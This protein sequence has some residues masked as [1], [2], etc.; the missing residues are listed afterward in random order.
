MK[1]SIIILLLYLSANTLFAQ[2]NLVPNGDFEAYSS[3]PTDYG[4]ANLAIGWNNVN[5]DY[6]NSTGSPDYFNTLSFIGAGTSFGV[7]AMLP[8]SGN[9]QIGLV[10]IQQGLFREYISS[11]F[12]S[13]MNIGQKYSISFYITN[14]IDN[15]YTKGSNNLGIH[16]SN[17]PLY[18]A[19]DE[20][21][22]VIP[23][24]EIDTIIY[25][26][27]EW[28]HFSF[29]YTADSSYN[30]IT[31]GNF[32]DDAHTL[33]SSY[34]SNGAYYFIDKIEI[35]TLLS[36]TGE[37][38]ICKGQPDTLR[39]Y[40]DTIVKWADSLNPGIIIA[41]DSIITIAP[42]VT[43]TYK[44]TTAYDT[45]YFT[46]HVVIPPVINLGN[47]TVL[48]PG[49]GQD[50]QL[51]VQAMPFTSYTWQDGSSGLSYDVN[52]AGTY[53]VKA[54]INSSCFAS[55]T[56]N[57]AYSSSPY[58]NLGNDTTLC[59]GDTLILNANYPNAS[60]QWQDGATSP[61]YY[62]THQGMY[63]V[64]VTNQYNCHTYN[65]ITISYNP[66]P[67]INFG[68]DTVLCKG[69]SL[70]LNATNPNSTYLWQDNSTD[71]IY[72]VYLQGTYW[73]KITNQYPCSSSDTINIAYSL[74]PSI[75]TIS[76][77]GNILTSSSA[78][79]NQWLLNGQV[80]TSDT[81]QS[82]TITLPITDTSCYSLTV[83]NIYGCSATSDTI[84]YLPLGISEVINNNGI[85]IYPNPSK[86]NITIE[87]NSY[88]EQRLEILNLIGQTVYT[89]YI[90]KKAV[91]NTSAF[92]KGVYI[93]KLSSDKET[94]VRKFVKE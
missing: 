68:N 23:Q 42:T 94:V 72:N 18:Q 91:I 85:Y 55:D 30:F 27:N 50:L 38:A 64:K 81:N 11:Q 48:C 69:Q 20:S 31:I 15:F 77:I 87:T 83:T 7:V 4:Q 84:C 51:N 66:S 45:A 57:V 29:N 5:G 32:K 28:H 25:F 80:I 49:T 82:Y 21:I 89:I 41:T 19:I 35:Y 92:A 43:T 88:K 2:F 17:N 54:T 33:V 13:P 9:G 63:W 34:G 61:I 70:L 52:Q 14:G 67:L 3:L 75:P 24:I 22:S 86:D 58:V 40:G 8:F 53:W 39:M 16:F 62:A 65:S 73:V 59:T 6:T 47:D 10:T 90:N 76:Q 26:W 46:V 71:S 36:I 93:L 37:V 74:N 60:Y 12:I 56:I 44:A 78:I 1:K 79:G